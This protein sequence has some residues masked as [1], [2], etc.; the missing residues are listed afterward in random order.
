MVRILVC[1][2]RDV[3]H[4]ARWLAPFFPP[5]DTA[6]ALLHVVAAAGRREL[7]W[8]LRRLPGRHGLDEDDAARI[9]DA[10]RERGR[11]LLVG[12]ERE[13]RQGGFAN[14]EAIL[15]AGEPGHEIVRVASARQVDVV[16]LPVAGALRPPPRPGEGRPPPPPPHH[17]PPPGHW[18]RFVVDHASCH[19]LVLRV[20]R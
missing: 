15:A 6:V 3:P 11:R 1:L 17:A 12:A 5:G 10:E 20:D 2:D 19:V 18:P 13:L 16:V 7:G 14:V 9:E 8:L 4:L